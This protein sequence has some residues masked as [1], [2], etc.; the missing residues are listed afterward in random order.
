MRQPQA[1][2]PVQRAVCLLTGVKV[3]AAQ[4]FH[5][6]LT[7]LLTYVAMMRF[8][9]H[10]GTLTWITVFPYL[11]LWCAARQA[12]GPLLAA[13]RVPQYL[14]HAVFRAHCGPTGPQK[15]VEEEGLA[16]PPRCV[17]ALLS[18]QP[19]AERERDGVEGGRP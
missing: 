18:L 9:Q 16:A 5:A 6:L 3:F 2:R 14:H 7:S 15:H 17:A 4:V 19:R 11:I 13:V 12:G 10:C 8:R 1:A